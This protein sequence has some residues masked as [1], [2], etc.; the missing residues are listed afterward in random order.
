MEYLFQ[1][2]NYTLGLTVE[3]HPKFNNSNMI[4]PDFLALH[5]TTQ[6]VVNF[7]KIIFGLLGGSEP[8]PVNLRPETTS[9]YISFFLRVTWSCDL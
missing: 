9:Y 7:F 4:H 3:T 1:N 2:S 6:K 5:L 8:K